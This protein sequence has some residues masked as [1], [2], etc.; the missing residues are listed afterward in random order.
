MKESLS[1]DRRAHTRCE[2]YGQN[3]GRGNTRTRI[4]SPPVL[5]S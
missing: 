4:I 3:S 1:S 2:S 5:T